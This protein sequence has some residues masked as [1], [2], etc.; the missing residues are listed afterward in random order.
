M[1]KD[2][3]K[4]D[5]H[6]LVK[7]PA[8]HDIEIHDRGRNDPPFIS[9]RYSYREVSSSDGRTHI[10]SKDKSFENGKFKS[11]EFEGTLDGNVYS[12]LVGAMQKHFLNQMALFMKPFSM[13]LP[14]GKS[15]D[16]DK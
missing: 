11:E 15:R 6:Q 12:D 14:L 10:R 4:K 5:N 13:F 3:L 8:E 9:F 16:K 2:M 1:G 7:R